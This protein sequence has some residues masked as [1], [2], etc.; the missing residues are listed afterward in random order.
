MLIIPRIY[1]TSLRI[2]TDQVSVFDTKMIEAIAANPTIDVE[3]LFTYN[4]R[5]LRVVIP[6][7]YEVKSLLDQNGYCGYLR[8][9]MILGSQIVD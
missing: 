8:L 3:V 2:E 9:A 5:K 7:G 6:A 4:G 1:G